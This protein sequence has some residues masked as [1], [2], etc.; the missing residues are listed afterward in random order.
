MIVV[1][2]ANK[3]K[4]HSNVCFIFVCSP[5]DRF[6]VTTSEMNPL[7]HVFIEMAISKCFLLIYIS[8]LRREIAHAR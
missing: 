5:D 6:D 2:K 8:S 1:R 3:L 4:G 7:V